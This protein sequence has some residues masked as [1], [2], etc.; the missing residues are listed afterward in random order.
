MVLHR[1]ENLRREFSK[2]NID[3]LLVGKPANRVY[4]S[5]FTGTYGFL[6][7]T[8]DRAYL[9]TDFRYRDQAE[10]QAP[11]FDIIMCNSKIGKT[12][13]DII[14]TGRIK[15]LGFEADFFT[16]KQYKDLK[17]EMDEVELIPAVGLT[18]K[19]RAEKEDGE[20]ELIKK[21]VEI[22][23]SAFEHILNYIEPGVAERDLADEL[24]YYMRKKGASKASFDI[25][26]ASGF[27]G[28]LPHG[29][30]TSKK[31][32]KGDMIILDYG[33]VFE[34]YC[35][36]MTRTVILGR[37]TEEQQRIYN[38][39]LE[40]QVKALDLVTAGK[41]CSDVDL[42]ARN[43]ISS[44]GYDENFGH[45][46]G[47]GVGIEVHEAP[48]LNK[49]SRDV[50]SP[51]MVVTVEPGIYIKGWGGVRIEDMVLV[52]DSGREI[53]TGTTKKMIEL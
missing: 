35:S 12:I 50:L 24:E 3:A 29:V 38:V 33:A 53:L 49:S 26:V 44:H 2:Q 34:G 43:I 48:V 15:R 17:E 7:I 21:A 39:V 47:H 40:A 20:V 14:R 10:E 36:D 42:F 16:F 32:E 22:A 51:G 11:G 23:D 8:G 5:G 30:A 4:L 52:T 31:L 25:I 9:L 28:A 46:L 19:L 6:V 27:R 1:L 37:A 45:G 13:K 18:E 41:A